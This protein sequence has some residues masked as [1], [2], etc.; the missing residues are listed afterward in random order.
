MNRKHEDSADRE[1]VAYYLTEVKR[2]P[3]LTAEKEIELGRALKNGNA[4]ARD[5]L[6]QANLR[7]VVKIAYAY[8]NADI[9][10]MDLIQEGNIGLVHAAEK[11]D[12]E[13]GVRFSTYSA[14]WIKQAICRFLDSKKRAI[15]LPS[16]KE[17]ML[18]KIQYVYHDL[19]QKLARVPSDREI[20]YELGIDTSE[21]RFLTERG[22]DTV[23]L[24]A[25]FFENT[26]FSADQVIED[27]T[28][29]PEE[30]YLK[31]A[32]THEVLDFLSSHL[33]DR[34]KNV[35]MC[36]FEL[37]GTSEQH[38]LK[39][40]GERIGVSP[41]AVRQ[42]ELRALRKIKSDYREFRDCLYA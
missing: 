13:K 7:L 37:N 12:P 32:A 11:F 41:E 2:T 30:N 4:T 34:E 17:E 38:S 28:Y 8:C 31:E 36:R 33:L 40:I 39:K 22:A 23:S 14:L 27:Y 15:R 5:R 6:V 25:E 20:A 42:I 35:L 16:R 10:L 21:V 3:L 1:L 18:R 24:E 26:A 19:M 29:S 9:S